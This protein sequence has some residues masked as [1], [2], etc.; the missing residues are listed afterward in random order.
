[1]AL[2]CCVLVVALVLSHNEFRAF[3]IGFC[4]EAM[5][6]LF[7][8]VWS[9]DVF[10]FCL[11]IANVV[12]CFALLRLLSCPAIFII[13]SDGMPAFTLLLLRVW[14]YLSLFVR[15]CSFVQKFGF[16][17]LRVRLLVAGRSLLTCF[18]FLCCHVDLASCSC[19]H[20]LLRCCAV[21]DFVWFS[22]H[23]LSSPSARVVRPASSLVVLQRH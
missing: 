13:L 16:R 23:F 15:N 9:I 1:M 14:L 20:V 10:S 18:S 3:Q 21:T 22:F 12:L 5:L 7:A 6:P 11:S 2:V 17:Q 19:V 4:L 8:S